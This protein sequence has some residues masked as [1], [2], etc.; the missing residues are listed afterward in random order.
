[1]ISTLTERINTDWLSKV[2]S[3]LRLDYRTAAVAWSIFSLARDIG[4]ALAYGVLYPTSSNVGLLGDPGPLLHDCLVHPIMIAYFCWLQTNGLN[5]FSSLLR[6]NIVRNDEETERILNK[7]LARLRNRRIYWLAVLVSTGAI[8]GWFLSL[9]FTPVS[10]AGLYWLMAHPMLLWWTS[11]A[12]FVVAY[13]IAMSVYDI[14]IIVIGLNDLFRHKRISVD[15]LNPDGAGGL[16]A[17]GQLI[18]S[19][20]YVIA[21]L[22]ATYSVLIL[23]HGVASRNDTPTIV[24]IAF[25]VV[26]APAVFLTPL[27]STHKKMVEFRNDTLRELAGGIRTAFSGFLN[28]QD[29]TAEQIESLLRNTQQ[30]YAM[31]DLVMRFPT[32]PVNTGTFRK[33]FGLVYS[34]IIPAVLSLGANLLK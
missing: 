8:L 20:G 22:G 11:P 24:G 29:H 16:G 31:R 14:A 25:Y 32:W 10:V 12:I 26:L 30:T 28:G 18:S 21:A 4:L 19:L 5:A 9:R 7:H 6:E 34:T 13:A 3:S 33:F 27:W 17:I 1:M 2:M 23:L 15:I